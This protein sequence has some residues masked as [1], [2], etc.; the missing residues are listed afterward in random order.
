[1]FGSN[2]VLLIGMALIV[3]VVFWLTFHYREPKATPGGMPAEPA[4]TPA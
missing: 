1:M 2:S 3:L 4:G